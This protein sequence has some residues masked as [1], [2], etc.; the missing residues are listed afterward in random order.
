MKILIFLSVLLGV[1]LAM[2]QQSVG[3]RGKLVCGNKPAANVK[4]KLMDKD[5]G[6]SY[7]R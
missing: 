6:M 2:R 5:T 7:C 4:V 1:S 3:V